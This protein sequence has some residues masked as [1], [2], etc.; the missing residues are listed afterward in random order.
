M[1]I[2]WRL[3]WA[4]GMALL[5][6]VICLFVSDFC[7]QVLGSFPIAAFVGSFVAKVTIFIVA[8]VFILALVGGAPAG[9]IARFRRPAPPR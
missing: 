8:I 6:Y 7:S 9:L 1:D 2:L 4:V 3:V 5:A